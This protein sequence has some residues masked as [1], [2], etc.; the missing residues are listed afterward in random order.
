MVHKLADSGFGFTTG[1]VSDK[2]TVTHFKAND[3]A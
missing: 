1:T 3:M 2:A